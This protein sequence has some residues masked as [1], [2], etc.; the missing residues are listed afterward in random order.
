M[1]KVTKRCLLLFLL[2]LAAVGQ[3]QAGSTK[4]KYPGGKCYMYRL[5]LKDKAANGFSLQHPEQFLSPRA[6]ERRRRQGLQLDSTDLPVSQR[7]V[8]QVRSQ[9]VEVVGRSKWNNT[10]LVRGNSQKTLRALASLPFVRRAVK[11][12]TSPDSLAKPVRVNYR[13]EFNEWDTVTQ[14]IYGATEEQI[15]QLNG[16]RLHQRGFR[17]RGMTIAVLDGGFMNA[18]QIPCLQTIHLLGTRDFVEPPSKDIFKEMDHGTMVLSAMAVSVPNYFTGT[19]PDASYWLLRCEDVQTETLAEEDYW[20]SAA[21]FADSVGVDVINSSLGFHA[22]DDAAMN[23]QYSELDGHQALISHSASL[24]AGKGIVLVSSAGNEGMG[25]WKKINFPADAHDIITVGAITPKGMN[26]SFSSIGPTA[27][28][29]IKPDVMAQGSP[30]AVVTGRGTIIRDIGTSFSAPQVAGLV[31]CLWQA[32]PQRTALEIVEAVRRCGNRTD[33]PDDVFGYGVPDFMKAYELLKNEAHLSSSPP[34][35]PKGGEGS[36]N[37]K[38]ASPTGGGLVGASLSPLGE[39]EGA[40]A[41][42][43]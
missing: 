24:L 30:A 9:G 40:S 37:A 29:R 32:C 36:P 5:Y 18:D 41:N 6:L 31:A 19:A 25:T 27:D 14:S 7:Y 13:R 43:R 2:V 20:A 8:E 4:V 12:W 39:S 23:H 3:L 16:I 38:E 1:G 15:R 21:E 26:A 17:G 42:T 35:P 33:Q 34:V 11:V 28:G 10:L 22:F